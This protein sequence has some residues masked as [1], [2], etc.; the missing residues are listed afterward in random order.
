MTLIHEGFL[1]ENKWAEALYHKYA[2]DMPIFDYHCH[3]KAEDLLKN[4]RYPN[5]TR[6]WLA[7]DHYKWRLMRIAG[8][9]EKYITGDGDDYDK[10][11]LWAEVVSKAVGNP[12]YH[13]THL[14]LKRYFGIDETLNR[15]TAP[16]IWE[17][18]SNM[19]QEESFRTVSF[20]ERTNV[21]GICTI[22]DPVDDLRSHQELERSGKCGCRILPTFRPDQV[23][24][25]G[26][27]GY[28]DWISK[29]EL[30]T[31]IIIEDLED[32]EEAL[33]NRCAYF[34]ENGCLTAD[35]AIELAEFSVSDRTLAEAAFV[36]ARSGGS[37][38]ELEN[39]AYRTE[40]MLFLAKMYHSRGLVMQL[41]F[42]AIRNINESMFRRLGPDTGFDTMGEGISIRRIAPLF[43]RL[44][45]AGK[46][47]KTILFPSGGLDHEKLNAFSNCF[48][49]EKTR[50]KVQTGAPWWFLD[51]KD[52]IETY[53]KSFGRQG[54]LSVF[55]GML[56][57]SRSI[58]SMTRHEYFRR[59]LCN[60]LGTWIEKGELQNDESIL[61]E[62]IRNICYYNAADYFHFKER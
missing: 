50:G 44:S 25:I 53:L 61:E 16:D 31:G 48:S 8:I 46:L 23:F 27:S 56:T 59:I 45:S 57:D 62:I 60:L 11:L 36:K 39:A 33:D 3:L 19:L 21:K 49:E 51:H 42:G 30:V 24:R 4:G 58:L 22:D 6:V 12:I 54:M 26:T 32:L 1:L 5:L 17:K 55:I 34:V 47:P 2:A 28:L 14:E 18:C 41:H 15:R 20:L 43:N 52:G 29:L 9:E 35:Q 38:S 13:W 7:E 37:I 40:I 10:F